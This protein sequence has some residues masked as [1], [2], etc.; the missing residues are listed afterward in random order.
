MYPAVIVHWIIY[1]MLSQA[2]VIER[3][4]LIICSVVAGTSLVALYWICNVVLMSPNSS[5]PK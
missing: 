2:H 1:E 5:C 4:V 3:S